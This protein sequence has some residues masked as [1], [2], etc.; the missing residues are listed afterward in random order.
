M[1]F[2]N[3]RFVTQPLSGVQRY[4]FEIC[5]H[6]K[7]LSDQIVFLCPRNIRQHQWAEQLGVKV[8]GWCRGH[9]WEQIDL[10]VFL[11]TQPHA[12]LFSPC[13]TGPLF[14]SNQL[15]TL[16]DLSFKFYPAYNHFLFSA[17]YNFLVVRL[18][19]KVKHI[20]TVSESIKAEIMLHYHIAGNKISVTYNGIADNMRMNP[21]LKLQKEKMILT[22]GSFHQRKNM[23]MLVKAF[24]SADLAPQYSLV[25]IGKSNAIF[26]NSSGKVYNGIQLI[27]HAD[28]AMLKDYY[29]NAEIACFMS[30]Y[31]GFGIPVLEALHYGCKVIC[32]DIPVNRELYTGLVWFCDPKDQQMLSNLLMQLPQCE[33]LQQDRMQDAEQKYNYRNSASHIYK[34]LCSA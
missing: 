27:Q 17:W 7:Q 10:P 20:F 25:A 30:V 12:V 5:R 22:V 29:A 11:A 6:L 1:I 14:F 33:P 21:R 23:N 2:V 32:A 19:R 26:S 28:D 18:C 3:A 16:H 13:N 9:V 8:I 15:L 34:T 4:A 24:S 31:E